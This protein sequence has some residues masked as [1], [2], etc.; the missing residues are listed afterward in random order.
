[1]WHSTFYIFALE[2]KFRSLRMETLHNIQREQVID[3]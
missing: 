2:L 1:M 3:I